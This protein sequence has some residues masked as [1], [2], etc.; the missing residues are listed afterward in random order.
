MTPDSRIFPLCLEGSKTNH[1]WARFKVIGLCIFTFHFISFED[2]PSGKSSQTHAHSPFYIS[3][4]TLPSYVYYCLSVSNISQWLRFPRSLKLP[5]PVVNL[6]HF[7]HKSRVS[8]HNH[9]INLPNYRGQQLWFFLACL[10]STSRTR[11]IL[12]IP[13]LTFYFNSGSD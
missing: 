7:F 8:T 5:Q 10:T 2:S 1:H 13:L 12:S 4:F 3:L 9:S 6:F 11:S